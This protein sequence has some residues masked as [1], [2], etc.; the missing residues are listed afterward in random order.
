MSVFVYGQIR[1]HWTDRPHA[2]YPLLSRWT[3]GMFPPFGY[4]GT[5]PLWTF[6]YVFLFQHLFSILSDI[7][8][9]IELVGHM[10]ILCV[11]YGG[12]PKL[13][14]RWLPATTRSCQQCV[15]VPVSSHPVNTVTV[16]FSESY[17]R[18]RVVL[19]MVV[20]Y[21]S[22]AVNDFE[23]LFICVLAICRPV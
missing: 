14:S 21:G 3:F 17:P 23:Y 6:V 9:G 20:I 15:K 10:V 18:M 4:L 2:V 11:T 12:T 16:S 1:F 13:L 19:C 8:L 22:L 7:Y 5:V